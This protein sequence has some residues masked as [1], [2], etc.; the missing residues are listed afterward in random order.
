MGR[1]DLYES[2]SG[3]ERIKDKKKEEK[4]IKYRWRDEITTNLICAGKHHR[5][6]GLQSPFK[7]P[8]G[9]AGSLRWQQDAEHPLTFTGRVLRWRAI[10]PVDTSESLICWPSYFSTLRSDPLLS[11]CWWGCFFLDLV[12]RWVVFHCWHLIL[13]KAKRLCDQTS[14]SAKK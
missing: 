10:L 11:H 3:E 9:S 4:A 6:P 8:Q 13:F 12:F 14:L 2:K 1:R 5:L 7:T